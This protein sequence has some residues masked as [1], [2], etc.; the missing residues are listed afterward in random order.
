MSVGILFAPLTRTCSSFRIPMPTLLLDRIPKWLPVEGAERHKDIT[1]GIKRFLIKCAATCSLSCDF[2]IVLGQD[3]ECFLARTSD[4]FPFRCVIPR[5]KGLKIVNGN[6]AVSVARTYWIRG[7]LALFCMNLRTLDI[8]SRN[9]IHLMTGFYTTWDSFPPLRELCFIKEITGRK[10]KYMKDA[11]IGVLFSQEEIVFY[12]CFSKV[13]ENSVLCLFNY[14]LFS[15][16]K[17]ILILRRFFLY[18][19]LFFNLPI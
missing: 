6:A 15:I 10:K 8:G 18:L 9:R 1:G 3:N 14:Q 12:F 13:I 4:A 2:I 17:C 11:I 19:L 7:K 16:D 5:E